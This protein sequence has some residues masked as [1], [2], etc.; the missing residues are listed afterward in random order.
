MF[1]VL[2]GPLAPSY[3]DTVQPPP[4]GLKIDRSMDI[5]FP[6]GAPLRRGGVFAQ[7]AGPGGGVVSR[8]ETWG[9]ASSFRYAPLLDPTY[10]HWVGYAKKGG[11]YYPICNVCEWRDGWAG[12][13]LV[14][15]YCVRE[16]R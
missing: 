10:L 2:A 6:P 9:P 4:T 12:Y 5:F 1:H 7:A 13:I 3:L 11:L 8:G 15:F 16:G 14:C